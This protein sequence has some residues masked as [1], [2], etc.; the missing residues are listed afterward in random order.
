MQAGTGR[1]KIKNP[2][3]KIAVSTVYNARIF[4]Y[5]VFCI[6][7]AISSQLLHIL[8]QLHQTVS[9]GLMCYSCHI[10][11]VIIIIFYSINLIVGKVAQHQVK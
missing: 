8:P 7:A 11:G 6:S 4:L 2:N 5:K 3:K 10:H 9:F 1:F